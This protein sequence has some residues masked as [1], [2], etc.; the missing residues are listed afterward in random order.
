MSKSKQVNFRCDP[1]SDQYRWLINQNSQTQ[2][3]NILI[4]MAIN[5]FGYADLDAYFDKAKLDLINNTKLILPNSNNVNNKKEVD[6]RTSNQEIIATTN[7][8]FNYDKEF[9]DTGLTEAIEQPKKEHN[10]ENT[11][12]IGNKKRKKSDNST[13]QSNIADKRK[14]ALAKLGVNTSGNN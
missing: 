1:S 3:I 14:K 5:N 4:Q 10:E 12:K 11:N 6:V 13:S 2:S 8:T 7:E 9:N